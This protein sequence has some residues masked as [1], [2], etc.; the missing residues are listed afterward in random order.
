MKVNKNELQNALEIVKPGLAGK[1]V[2]EQSTSFAFK[3]DRV[4]T[5]NDEISVSHPVAGLDFEGAV[6]ADELY[7]LLS[8]INRSEVSVEENGSELRVTAGKVKAGLTFFSEI[9]LPL[10]NVEQK[11]KKI[12]NSKDFVEGLKLGMNTCS[13]DLS[14][15]KLTCMHIRK[16]GLMY[17]TDGYRLLKYQGEPLPVKSFLLPATNAIQLVKMH[18]TH[19]C[20][21]GSWAHFKNDEDTIF[22]CR[23]FEDEYLPE[24]RLTSV[25][26]FKGKKTLT[27]PDKIIEILSRVRQLSKRDYAMDEKIDVEISGRKIKLRSESDTGSWVEEK[28]AIDFE[29]DFGFIITP[30]LFESILG[31]TRTCKIS[32][33]ADKVCFEAENWKY[34]IM[35]RDA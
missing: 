21:D 26:E 18:P 16:D 24:E 35:L 5:Y 6:K 2:I 25:L 28:A 33:A 13:S 7:G 4:I 27:F 20:N 29:D 19:I 8:K 30:S 3:G 9:N 23:L 10:L 12:K 32:N 14:E 11:F 22:S 34:V 15:P 1:E 31:V 17:A